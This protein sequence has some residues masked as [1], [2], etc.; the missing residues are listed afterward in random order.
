MLLIAALAVNLLSTAAF[1][2]PTDSKTASPAKTEQNQKN[3]NKD[4]HHE[5]KKCKDKKCKDEFIDPIKA[6]KEKK[7][8]IIKLEKEGKISKEEA[9]KRIK[10]IDSR[11][12][13]IEEFN[14]LTLEQKRAK[15]IEKFK[16]VMALKVKEGKISQEKADEL[17]AEYTK[18]VQEWD[19][20]GVPRFYHKGRDEH[21]K[22][23]E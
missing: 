20:K 9:D 17:I 4:M 8:A 10:K 12:K 15:L 16:E 14:K 21:N 23:D 18:K 22:K 19:G 6:L 13:E 2:V 1:A 11:I 5:Q 7:E 3:D